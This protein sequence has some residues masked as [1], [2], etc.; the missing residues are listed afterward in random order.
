MIWK[1]KFSKH[2]KKLQTKKTLKF[3]LEL[4]VNNFQEKKMEKFKIDCHNILTTKI[5]NIEFHINVISELVFPSFY[6][7]FYFIFFWKVNT[8]FFSLVIFIINSQLSL[9]P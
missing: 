6:T 4:N 2:L 7:S 1:V 9:L 8:K 5:D 3:Y